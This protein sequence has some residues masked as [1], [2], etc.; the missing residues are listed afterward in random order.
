MPCNLAS[1][2]VYFGGSGADGDGGYSDSRGRFSGGGPS[3]TLSINIK[4]NNRRTRCSLIATNGVGRGGDVDQVMV[5][6]RRRERR[7]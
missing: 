2:T 1:L 6:A 7:T 4:L 5:A 3:N